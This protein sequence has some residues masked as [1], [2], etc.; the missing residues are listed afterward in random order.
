MGLVA[1]AIVGVCALGAV[2]FFQQR[3]QAPTAGLIRETVEKTIG[4]PQLKVTGVKSTV[5]RSTEPGHASVAYQAEAEVRE[6]LYEPTDP[7]A[8]LRDELKLDPVAWQRTRKTL[9]GKTAPRILELAGLK[10]LDPTL[11]QTTFLHQTTA[12]GAKFSFNGNLSAVKGADGWQLTGDRPNQTTGELRGKP[13]AAFE[14]STTVI[15]DAAAMKKIHDLASAQA[16]VPAKVEAGRQAFLAERRAAQ[17]KVIADLVDSL[18]PGT[19]YGGTAT[20][21]G[22]AP[23]KIFLEFTSINARYHQVS[24]VLRSDGSWADQRV[25]KGSFAFDADSETLN[26]TLAT[27]ARQ[28]VPDAGDLL[29]DPEDWNV[30]LQLSGEKLSGSEHGHSFTLDRMSETAAAAA[31]QEIEAASTALVDATETGRVYRGS[32]HNRQDS[33]TYDYLLRFNQQ[34]RQ[35]A[36]FVATLEPAGREAW[37]RT[38]HGTI[39][40]NRRRTGGPAARL[41][42]QSNEAVTMADNRSP[43]GLNREDAFP[44]QLVDGH[45]RGE[46]TDFTYDFSPLTDADIAK[47]AAAATERE[48]A[49]LAI[50][51]ANTAYPGT[52]R[53]GS[54]GP[55]EKI[56]LRFRRVDPHGADVEAVIESIEPAGIF[57]EFRGSVDPFARQLPLNSVGQGRAAAGHRI[58]LK[59]P[60]LGDRGDQQLVLDLSGSAITGEMPARGQIWKVNFPV[61]GALEVTGRAAGDYPS[62]TGAYIWS[63]GEW[64][65]L[66]RNDAKV[67]KDALQAISG[68]FNALAKKAILTSSGDKIGELVFAGDEPVPAVNGADV[69]VLYVGSTSGLADKYPQLG[70]YPALEVAPSSRDSNGHRHVTLS[71]LAEGVPVGGFREQRVDGTLERVGDNLLEFN[72]TRRLAPGTYAIS[73]NE[74]DFEFNVQ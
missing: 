5:S 2:I 7:T 60:P 4:N 22:E 14:G 31:R 40:T 47:L 3:N 34:D 21:D 63:G 66:P 30:G 24:A 74:N 51:K 54:N 32:V 45:L 56:R 11:L 46:T 42:S 15:E 6:A 71:R 53:L 70:N 41:V 8:L 55:T 57:R 29:A 18:K 37:Q 67:S 59:F 28:A 17:E 36:T 23:L 1:A 69:R 72:C 58:G 35:A 10:D 38:Y 62:E 48:Q 19:I 43:V 33:S 68:F 50:V 64:Q 61:A 27:T 73:V 44:L 25:M 9:S 52:A 49:L 65:P 20:A 39:A 26:V 13:R 12:A 16:D